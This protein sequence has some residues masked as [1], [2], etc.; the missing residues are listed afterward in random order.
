MKS[1]WK[2]LGRNA[3]AGLIAG[4]ATVL[5]ENP[6]FMGIA[7]ILNATFKYLRDKNPDSW[8]WQIL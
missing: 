6:L 5:N 1:F 2:R 3:L 4:A 8:I 7:P